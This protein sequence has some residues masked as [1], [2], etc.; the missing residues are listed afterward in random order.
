MFHNIHYANHAESE[1]PRLTAT[2]KRSPTRDAAARTTSSKR[3]GRAAATSAL[4]RPGGPIGPIPAIDEVRRRASRR[5]SQPAS[6]QKLDAVPSREAHPIRSPVATRRTGDL[7]GVH[8]C[9]R[10]RRPRHRV[11]APG[12]GSAAAPAARSPSR[13]APAPPPVPEPRAIAASKGAANSKTAQANA[14]RE[15]EVE[16]LRDA[17]MEILLGLSS[18]D[19]YGRRFVR[20]A[21]GLREPHVRSSRRGR[22]WFKKGG[23][24]FRALDFAARL[25]PRRRR[26]GKKSDAHGRSRPTDFGLLGRRPRRRP[27]RRPSRAPLHQPSPPGRR[28]F[29]QPCARRKAGRDGG[30]KPSRSDLSRGRTQI[31]HRF[32]CVEINGRSGEIR[33]PTPCPPDKCANRAALHSD[34]APYRQRERRWQCGTRGGIRDRETISRLAS[35]NLT[36]RAPERELFPL[37]ANR[38]GSRATPPNPRPALASG[39]GRA[40][41]PRRLFSPARAR[42]ARGARSASAAPSPA[43]RAALLTRPGRALLAQQLLHPFDRVAFAVEKLLDRAQEFDVVGPIVAPAAAALERLDLRKSCFPEAQH[44]LRQLHVFGDFADRAES[45]G[46]LVHGVSLASPRPRS[47]SAGALTSAGSALIRDFNTLDGLKTI[48]RRGRIGTSTPV[49]GLRPMRWPFERTTKEP[50]EDSFT[51][52]PRAAASQIS[53]RTA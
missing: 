40:S 11:E 9:R 14:A 18:A 26:L 4:A 19:P 5:R 45:F 35:A 21:R 2:A 34:A 23:N 28:F 49:F 42:L 16:F 20:S 38:P 44:V 43:P 31:S 24:C 12:A 29:G 37:R 36:G 7:I 51:V 6:I 3:P 8:E 46:A 25:P 33:T 47:P 27:E 13:S 1:P 32:D 41:S 22:R 52:S 10:G 17:R 15:S 39:S 50:N 30:W 53:S 48:T